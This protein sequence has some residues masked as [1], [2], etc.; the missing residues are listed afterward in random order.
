MVPQCGKRSKETVR[1]EV[2]SEEYLKH[3]ILRFDSNLSVNKS[4]CKQ[5]RDSKIP[6]GMQ[7][8]LSN[9]HF[10]CLWLT[11]RSYEK[12]CDVWRR[13]HRW[14]KVIWLL[15]RQQ[16]TIAGNAHDFGRLGWP[17]KKHTP[18]ELMGGCWVVMV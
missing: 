3:V 5:R 16:S 4:F 14:S 2:C 13:A 9:S 12:V 17:G 11:T 6:Y 8:E 7:K 1:W 10:C 18:G 15:R